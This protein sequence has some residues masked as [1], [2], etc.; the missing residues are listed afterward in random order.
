MI[1]FNSYIIILHIIYNYIYDGPAQQKN[2]LRAHKYMSNKDGAYICLHFKMKTGTSNI[3]D[4]SF[5]FN[6]P[7]TTTLNRT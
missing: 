7:I 3:F 1:I 5:P 6:F 2:H 4:L